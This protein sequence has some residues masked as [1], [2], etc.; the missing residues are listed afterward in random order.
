M[1]EF[2]TKIEEHARMHDRLSTAKGEESDKFKEEHE[3]VKRG[4]DAIARNQPK[5]QL[6]LFH[7]TPEEWLQFWWNQDQ[8]NTETDEKRKFIFLERSIK[9]NQ[10]LASLEGV[11]RYTAAIKILEENLAPSKR[12]PPS[13]STN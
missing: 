13:S 9:C 10:T 1:E 4:K 3:D 6:K 8:V 5:T 7:G 2:K 11:T 12:K